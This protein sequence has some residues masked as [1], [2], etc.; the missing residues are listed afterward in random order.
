M[1]ASIPYN[2]ERKVINHEIIE[3]Y[4]QL[5]RNKLMND[6]NVRSILIPTIFKN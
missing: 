1:I 3:I 6:D 2:S 5:F 4:F